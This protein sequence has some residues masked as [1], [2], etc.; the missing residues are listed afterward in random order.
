M[1]IDGSR[2]CQFS[3][4]LVHAWNHQVINSGLF[5]RF[6]YSCSCV[7]PC[8]LGSLPWAVK[9]NED[10]PNLGFVSDLPGAHWL[11]SSSGRHDASTWGACP[12]TDGNQLWC[13]DTP[14]KRFLDWML[15]C[16]VFVAAQKDTSL[17]I[18]LSSSKQSSLQTVWL[19]MGNW[20]LCFRVWCDPCRERHLSSRTAHAIAQATVGSLV[21]VLRQGTARATLLLLSHPLLTGQ[22]GTWEHLWGSKYHRAF[23]LAILP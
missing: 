22:H 13:M 21:C 17:F 2:L 10:C 6:L 5:S 12:W 7:V 3:V 15:F 14:G 1:K 11:A 4:I 19:D 9:Q 20:A 8:R 18:S 16:F 23:L